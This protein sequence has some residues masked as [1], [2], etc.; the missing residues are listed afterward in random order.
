M[1]KLGLC[2]YNVVYI[3]VSGN[4]KVA[5][6]P[7]GRGNKNIQLVIKNCAPF[8]N[9]ISKINNTQRDNAKEIDVV[10]LMHNLI[11]YGNNHSKTLRSLWQY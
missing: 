10:M 1:L 7:A 5:V 11:E 6:L 4:I 3:L 9:W 8:I 2:G